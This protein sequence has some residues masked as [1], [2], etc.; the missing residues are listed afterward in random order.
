MN[1][2]T[3][4]N[5]SY[6]SVAVRAYTE[7]VKEEE[8]R[9]EKRRGGKAEERW[10][11]YVLIFDTETTIDTT[12]RL[13]FGA[14]RL[15]KWT[16]AGVLICLEAG[17]FHADDLPERDPEGFAILEAYARTHWADVSPGKDTTLYLY[18]RRAFVDEVFYKAAYRAHALVVCFNAP[19]DLSRIAVDCGAARGR[20]NGGFSFQLWEYRDKATGEYREHPYR[21]RVC[22]KHMDSKRALKGFTR[23]RSDDETGPVTFRGHFLDL[24]TLIF[25]LTDR[26]H[27]LDSACG[28]FGIATGE[29]KAKAEGHGIITPGYIAYNLQDVRATQTLLERGRAEY[30]R[31]PIPLQPTKA[32]SPASVAKEYLRAMGIRPIMERQ[33]D[34]SRDIL[35]YAMTA[36]FGGR[37]ECRIRHTPVPVVYCDFLS[38]YP[39]VN[40]LMDLWRFI[41]AERIE[42]VDATEEVRAFLDT[43][44]LESCFEQET[45]KGFT[46]FAEIE[47][48]GDVLPVRA[49]YS[50]RT[51]ELNIGVNPL[52]AKTPLWY[53]GPDLVASTLH[54]GKS[55]RIRRA[56]R[57]VH[58]GVQA[59][60]RPIRL[61]GTV[62]VNPAIDDLFR[63]DIEE[64]KRVQGRA[65]IPEEERD[66]LDRF[67]KVFANSGSYGIY[68]EMNRQELTGREKASVA[69]YGLDTPFIVKTN[70]P[71]IAGPFC[72]PPLAALIT[73]AAR[74]MLTLLERCVT[75]A[76]GAYAICD[77]DSLAIV[78]SEAGELISCHN[79][80]YRLPDGSPA[81]RAL[82]WVEVDAIVG[83]FA[84]LN[85]YDRGAVPGSV[86]KIEDDNYATVVDDQGHEQRVRRQLWCYSISAKRY[87]LFWYED[88]VPVVEE[89]P[90]EHGLGHLMNPTDPDSDEHDWIR[91]LW[92]GIINEAHGLTYQRP[93][94]LERP[95][96]TRMTVSSPHLRKPFSGMGNGKPYAER[97][98][99][100]NFILSAHIDSYGYPTGVSSQRF[101]LIA[102]YEA[103]GRKWQRMW[104]YDVYSGTRC[105]ITTQKDT[106]RANSVIVK[107][108]A[109]ELAKYRHHPEPKSADASG[110]ACGKQTKGLLQRRAVHMDRLMYVGKESNRLDDV[111]AGLV[112]E[113][114]E[115]RNEYHDP[116]NDPWRTLVVPVLGAMPRDILVKA[117]GMKERALRDLCK[118]RSIPRYY[119]TRATVI[120]AAAT[121][122]RENLPELTLRDD[123]SALS[124]YRDYAPSMSP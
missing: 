58:A 39:T 87:A 79:G 116:R 30:D 37:A 9:P 113:W 54:T 89:K 84:A 111:D 108:Y 8:E 38:M 82:S 36:Y 62:A 48:D 77:T 95:A 80:P 31:H 12:Q 93:E 71:E 13:N 43:I 20:F 16:R 123:L 81:I 115:V 106:Y 72:F 10:P 69:V 75:D 102:P 119:D 2:T 19:F 5:D 45:W 68:A 44:T 15:C 42:A 41:T 35:G 24:R 25:A 122:A 105:R 100:F 53:A 4:G 51:G 124:A 74:L 70:T 104:W 34:F 23:P 110:A 96:L 76:G 40:A 1:A 60:L 98:K 46:F 112:H 73:A 50:G 33:P 86:L 117:T 103:D 101:H 121:Y 17:L 64:R 22:V 18:S 14:Y 88:G 99:P 11:E 55:P 107:S 114:D 21:P 47:P 63:L 52:H 3:R 7:M 6:L 66:R 61:R 97:I 90:S 85:P 57:I 49:G 32:Y 29:G 83:R 109:D 27:S 26:G 65:D 91:S 94:W 59:G 118:G 92:Q 56:V 120:R 67:L 28:A 78:A